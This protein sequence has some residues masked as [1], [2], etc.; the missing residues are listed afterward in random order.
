MPGAKSINFSTWS[1]YYYTLCLH[2]QTISAKIDCTKVERWLRP[3]GS[4]GNLVCN[5][6]STCFFTTIHMVPAC[7]GIRITILIIKMLWPFQRES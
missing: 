1:I 7:A 3:D 5:L 4:S 2:K 6:L